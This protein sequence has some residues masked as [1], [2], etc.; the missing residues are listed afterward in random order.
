MKLFQLCIAVVFLFVSSPVSPQSSQNIIKIDQCGYYTTAPKIAVVTSDYKT[1]E[2][3]GSHFGF[4]VLKANVGDTVYKGVLGEIGQSVNSSLK[5]RIADFSDF[6]QKGNYV[7]YIPGIGDSW[8]FQ[9]NDDVHKNV[10][11]AILKG[12]Y[13]MRSSVPLEEKYA[14]KWHRSAGHPDTAVLVHPS[15]AGIKRPEGTVISTP[16]GWYDAGDYNKYIV[17]SGITTGTLLAA[18]ED[19]PRYFSELNTNIPESGNDVPDILDEALYNI[20]WMLSMQ[21]PYDGG[22]YNK[23]TN[24]AFDPMVSPGV[25]KLPRYVVQKGT[26]ATLDFAAVMA[27]ASRIFKK[28]RAEYPGLADSLLNAAVYSWKWAQKNPG[29]V[30]NQ[31]AI[32]KRFEPAITTGGYG[33][34]NFTDE[35][36]WAATELL[37]TTGNKMYYDTISKH[38]ADSIQLPSWGNVSMLGYYTM[39]RQRN[40][41]PSFAKSTAGILAQR[42]VAFAKAYLPRIANNAF[43][44]VMGASARE[45]NWGSNSSAANEGIALIN[46][47]LITKD[48]KYIDAALTNMDYLLGR[49][50]TGYCFVTGTG[51][52]SPMRPHHRPSI[53]D[54]IEDPVPG[55]LVGGPNPGMQDHAYYEHTEPETAYSDTDAS[56]A[57]NEIAINWNAP[58]VYLFNAIEA[59]QK[60]VGY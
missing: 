19:F 13:Y 8:P 60:E 24:A 9:I 2:Y 32:N 23:C 6:R 7:L 18:Y 4:Y 34:R 21:D 52:K 17:N 49:N 12:F 47:Y 22:V 56:Y 57:S 45:F 20:R 55:L 46:A 3:A 16:G 40:F 11:I 31:N 51:Y 54:G 30:Y 29:V 5:T 26:A 27:Q 1:D 58:A 28:Y 38:A 37:G 48:K 14:G 39:A 42:I 43:G 53:A 41:L 50:A 59:L 10:A 15:A 35:W 44:T 36:F 25:T 33:D